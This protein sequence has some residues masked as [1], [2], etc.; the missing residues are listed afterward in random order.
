MAIPQTKELVNRRDARRID[1]FNKYI[2]NKKQV[3]AEDAPWVEIGNLYVS[4]TITGDTSWLPLISRLCT[5]G[6]RKKFIVFTGRH[7]GVPNPVDRIGRSLVFDFEHFEQDEKIKSQ[8]LS[9]F[10]DISIELIDTGEHQ[11]DQVKWLRDETAKHIARG[12]SVIYSWCYGIFTMCE[13]P[14]D[15]GPDVG[16]SAEGWAKVV[17]SNMTHLSTK[18]IAQINQDYWH[19]VPPNPII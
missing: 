17:A 13:I 18:T 16:A 4:V 10:S 7:G 15:L 5:A 8:A 19:W 6:G 14:N 1:L 2:M 12:A 11:L 3:E 9:K